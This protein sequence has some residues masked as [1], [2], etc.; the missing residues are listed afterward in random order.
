MKSSCE[1]TD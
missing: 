1:S